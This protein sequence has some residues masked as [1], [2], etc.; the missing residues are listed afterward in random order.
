MNKLNIERRVQYGAEKMLDVRTFRL[1]HHQMSTGS[2]GLW[3]NTDK[4]IRSF[5]KGQVLQMEEISR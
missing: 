3:T 1:I 4:L 2:D 5:R